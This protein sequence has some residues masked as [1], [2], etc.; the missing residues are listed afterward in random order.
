MV[1]LEATVTMPTSTAVNDAAPV[2]YLEALR[3]SNAP[4]LLSRRLKKKVT[5][6]TEATSTTDTDGSRQDSDGASEASGEATLAKGV[7]AMDFDAIPEAGEQAL[8]TGL[9]TGECWGRSPDPFAYRAS[10]RIHY[11]AFTEN[12]FPTWPTETYST[13][14]DAPLMPP[15]APPDFQPMDSQPMDSQPMDSHGISLAELL[16]QMQPQMQPMA[17]SSM[18]QMANAAMPQM[19]LQGL[20]QMAAAAVP[21]Q[22]MASYPANRSKGPI[23]VP[24]PVPVPMTMPF[25]MPNMPNMANMMP[26]PVAVPPGFK[27]VRIPESTQ[28]KMPEKKTAPPK[29]A[30]SDPTQTECKIFVGGLNP[31]TTGQSLRDYFTD[32]G[33]VVDAKVIREGERSKGFGFVQF[34]ESIPA[35]VLE[36]SHI[37]D[38]RRC[39]VGPAFHDGAK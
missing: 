22:S 31:V 23:M 36:R 12:D 6:E 37:I 11:P 29:S 30:I 4:S 39:G 7:P 19:T 24:V 14:G 2:A 32:F 33:P 8:E 21:P 27:L 34:Q 35:A 5:A 20:Q 28:E 1:S 13:N 26:P 15:M 38:Q 3:G 25:P 9:M 10:G 16:P 18:Q 17:P